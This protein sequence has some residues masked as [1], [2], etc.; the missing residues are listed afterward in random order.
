MED[1]IQ[2]FI[3]YKLALKLREK[4]FNYDCLFA[5][6]DEQIINP[7][8]VEKYGELSDD[9]Y[10]EL[11]KDGGGELDWD[12]V[13]I[14]ETQLIPKNYIILKRN[15]VEAPTIALVLKWL[16]KEKNIDVDV[17]AAAGMLGDK[18]YVPYISTYTEFYLETSPDVVRYRQ[19]KFNPTTPLPHEIIPAHVYFNEW[20][21]AALTAIEYVLN[22]LI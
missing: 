15:F 6:N 13:Y 17:Q 5:Y 11:T 21:E 14:Y 7:E 2:D 16:R 12:Y 19:K 3:P 9:G 4:G 22:K 1:F 18:V 8:V 20:E 10:Y